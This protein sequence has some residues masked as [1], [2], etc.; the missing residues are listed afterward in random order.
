[1]SQKY[2]AARDLCGSGRHLQL[3]FRAAKWADNRHRM[4]FLI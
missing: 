4:F 2:D 3:R 1:M